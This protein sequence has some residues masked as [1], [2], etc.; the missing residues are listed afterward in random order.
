MLTFMRPSEETIRKVTA[1]STSHQ[2]TYAEV[3][4][5]ADSRTPAGYF[6]NSWKC[7]IGVGE[8]VFRRAQEAVRHY[9][10]LN[11]GWLQVVHSEGPPQVGQHVTTLAKSFGLWSL[12]VARI[13]QVDDACETRFGFCYGT[14]PEYPVAGEER[15]TVTLDEETGEVTF[16]LFSFSRP[17][18][19]PARIGWP[20]IRRT[21]RSFCK[22]S[23]RKM[24]QFCSRTED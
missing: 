12:N 15:F 18:A 23:S 3:L 4:A 19:I 11:L 1:A 7:R 6:P 17:T 8:A 13:V 16:D 2:L 9:Q 20:L 10:M 14:L 22:E 24:Q 5:S 21:Q